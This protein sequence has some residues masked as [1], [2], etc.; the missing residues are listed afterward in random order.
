MS[1]KSYN[2]LIVWQKGIILV[3]E[4]YKCTRAFPKEELYG[5]TSQIRRAAVSVPSNIAEG[6]SRLGTAEFRNFLSIARGSAAEVETQIIIATRLAYIDKQ[7][8]TSLLKLTV[9]I[10]KMLNALIGKLK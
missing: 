8:E 1:V 4:V 3:E 9:E 6:Q 7:S 2:E 5:L 10:K